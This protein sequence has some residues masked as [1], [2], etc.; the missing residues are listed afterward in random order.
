MRRPPSRLAALLAALVVASAGITCTDSTGPKNGLRALVG[1]APVLSTAA[2]DVY[3]NLA[4]FELAITNVRV[5]LERANGDIAS[6]TVIA[7]VPGQDSVVLQVSVELEGTQEAFEAR[8]ELRDGDLVLFSGTQ[9]ITAR[10]GIPSGPPPPIV[11]EF[12][13]PGATVTSLDV[14]PD[15]TISGID[16]IQMRTIA[17][18]AGGQIGRASCRERVLD[19]V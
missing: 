17:R 16:D 11:L 3:R 15:T 18:D 5:R 13:G 7:V 9:T 14:E 4:S 10:V 6:D 19:H 2:T 8:V 1:F 12:T